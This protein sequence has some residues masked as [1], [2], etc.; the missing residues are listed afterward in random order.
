[1]KNLFMTIRFS[2]LAL[3]CFFQVEH[4]VLTADVFALAFLAV[5]GYRTHGLRLDVCSL[6][7][8]Q[9]FVDYQGSWK[10]ASA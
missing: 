3:E 9:F 5:R 7:T 8:A 10:V 6:I 2:L 4:D 1:M